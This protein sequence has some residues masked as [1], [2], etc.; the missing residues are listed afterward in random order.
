M[1]KRLKFLHQYA[2]V[3][4]KYNYFYDWSVMS[5]GAGIAYSQQTCYKIKTHEQKDVMSAGNLTLNVC[6]NMTIYT[7]ILN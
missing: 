1:N 5:K 3:P 4:K 7:D 2:Y 6:I